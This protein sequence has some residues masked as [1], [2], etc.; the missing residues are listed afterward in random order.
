MAP[1]KG[2]NSNPRKGTGS[3]PALR[4]SHPISGSA[5]ALSTVAVRHR[6]IDW[7]AIDILV[8]DWQPQAFVVGLPL[9]LDGSEQEMTRHARSF[10]D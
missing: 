6:A 10:A 1:I 9:A 7:S 4:I 2:G 3:P 8:K 5:R